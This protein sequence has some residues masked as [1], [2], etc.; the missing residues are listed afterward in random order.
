[1]SRFRFERLRRIVKVMNG[2]LLIS[3]ASVLACVVL[4]ACVGGGGT[5]TGDYQDTQDS[6][7]RTAE[8]ASAS[9]ERSARSNE[10]VGATV[11]TG[12]TSSGGGSPASGSFDC[13]GTYSCSV[14]AAG[15]TVTQTMRFPGVCSTSEGG[16]NADGTITKNGQVLATWSPLPGGGFSYTGTTTS[17][18][19][20]VSYT[21][22]CT[23][24]SDS[25]AVDDTSDFPST[26]SDAGT[27]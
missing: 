11:E 20:T 22:N 19:T 24:V 10:G 6:V 2:Q 14:S 26:T 1:M 16:F 5:V 7:S 18:G 13:N 17:K 3:S 8:G 12:G 4:V 9:V 23:K 15:Q 21:V 25:A 27:R